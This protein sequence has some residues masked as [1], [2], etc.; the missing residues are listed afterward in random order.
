MGIEAIPDVLVNNDRAGLPLLP[1]GALRH[2]GLLHSLDAIG[3]EAVE[4]RPPHIMID[5]AIVEACILTS[6][7]ARLQ[8]RPVG[9]VDVK[10]EGGHLP[11]QTQ[12]HSQSVR[13][14]EGGSA[15]LSG[16]SQS[17]AQLGTGLDN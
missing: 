8:R 10:A 7:D 13:G 1:R 12:G 11:Q 14:E 2:P 9:G 4:P 5:E 6:P 15:L 17:A 3:F 16:T